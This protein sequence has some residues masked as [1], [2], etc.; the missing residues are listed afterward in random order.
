RLDFV[1]TFECRATRD[2]SRVFHIGI[3]L[4]LRGPAVVDAHPAVSAARRQY[5]ERTRN[6]P[7]RLRGA[8]PDMNFDLICPYQ[9]LPHAIIILYSK[10][11]RGRVGSHRLRCEKRG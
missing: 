11:M 10:R 1:G 9:A 5:V 8:F 3:D 2:V 7:P 4:Y 6:L